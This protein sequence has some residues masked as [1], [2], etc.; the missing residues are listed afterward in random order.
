M[1]ELRRICHECDGT[2]TSSPPPPGEPA[3]C[4][5]CG[6][7]GYLPTFLEVEN[8]AT[9]IAAIKAKTDNLPAD[10]GSDLAAIKA[11]TDNLPADTADI[12][13]DTKDKVY[14]NADKLDDIWEKLNE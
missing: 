13:D 14:D 8:L 3:G 9:E 11:K 6:S 2:G 7:T 1:A 12:L 5:T 10:I 4:I